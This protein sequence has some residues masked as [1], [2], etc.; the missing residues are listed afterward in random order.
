MSESPPEGRSERIL[1][2]ARKRFENFG[3]RHTSIAEIADDAGVAA[4]TIYWHFE[5]K[6]ALFLRLIDAENADWLERARAALHQPGNALERLARLARGSMEFY[7]QSRLMLAVLRR[8]RSMIHAPMLDS[9]HVRLQE[10]TVSLMAQVLRDGID[11]GSMRSVEPEKAAYVLFSVGHA[12]FNQS[13]HPYE[14]LADVLA[15][16]TIHGLASRP[17]AA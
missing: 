1:A 4:G 17:E 9:I 12:L 15:D 7:Q 5:S 3:F 11:D 2:A 14:D 13:D 10:Q 16:I 8:D 6:E